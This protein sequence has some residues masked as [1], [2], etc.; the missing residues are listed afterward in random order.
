MSG[1]V[2]QNIK[3]N[4]LIGELDGLTHLFVPPGPGDESISIGAAYI[5]LINQN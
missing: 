2:A 4:K 1:G 3:A 5:E